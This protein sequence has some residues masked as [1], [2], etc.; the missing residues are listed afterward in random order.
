MP[1]HASACGLEAGK[2]VCGWPSVTPSPL[3]L[4]PAATVT[5]TPSA[6]PSA[7]ALSS[8]VIDWPVQELSGPPQ[9]MLTATGVGVA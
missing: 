1:P 6:A 9:L 5:V 3:P 2:S 4:S 7:M 8:A